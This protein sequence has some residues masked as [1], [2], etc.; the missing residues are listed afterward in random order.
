M[1]GLTPADR[2][3]L[4]TDHLVFVKH[5]AKGLWKLPIEQ[6][7]LIA[8]G[9][10]ALLRC[11]E[12]WDPDK[13]PENSF[14]AFAYIRVRGAMI[15]ESRRW[16]HWRP[17]KKPPPFID[18]WET[19]ENVDAVL[20][21]K[22]PLYLIEELSQISQLPLRERT[23]CLLLGLGEPQEDIAKVLGVT[24]SRVSQILSRARERMENM[25][26]PV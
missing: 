14:W 19:F 1:R 24:P 20:P 3:R 18:S 26:D 4:I 16:L 8:A 21:K 9:N 22:N 23:A 5:T 12:K 11:V 25:L 2:N 6:D 10:E 13:A 7:D 15:D 17:T